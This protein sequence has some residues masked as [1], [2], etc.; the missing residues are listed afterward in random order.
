MKNK[1][2]TAWF[3]MAT[4]SVLVVCAGTARGQRLYIHVER[5]TGNISAV[6]SG[7][8]EVDGYS[9]TS[10]AGLLNPDAWNSLA[11]QG[12]EGWAEA[13][14]R[15]QQL[16]ELNWAGAGAVAAGQPVA[17]GSPYNSAGVVPGQEDLGFQFSTP[18]GVLH[19]GSVQYTGASQVPGIIVNRES[20]LIEVANPLGFEITGY[21]I[22]SSSGALQPDSF[23]GLADQNVAGWEEA[24]PSSTR[25]SKLNLENSLTV[26][27]ASPFNIGSAFVPGGTEDLV[28]EYL[29]LENELGNGLVSYTGPPSNLTLQVDLLSGEAKIQN[30][31]SVAGDFDIIGYSIFSESGSLAVDDWTSFADTG[32]GG[33]GWVEANPSG[34]A[35]AELN[36][37]GVSALFDAG[38]SISI[39]NVFTGAEDLVFEYGTTDGAA[40][41]AVE[42]VLNLGGDVLGDCNRDGVLDAADL[43]C[44]GT[45]EERDAVLTALNTLA[46]DLDGNGDVAFPDFLTLSANFGQ[47]LPS[48]TAGNIDL[49]GGV[50]FPDFLT[51]SAN[52]GK[53]PGGAA[54]AVP[55]PASGLL[56]TSGM[57]L[58]LAIRKRR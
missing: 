45:I 42:Y 20:G 7:D 48:Y 57:L 12:A 54:A 10:S 9:I 36:P 41:G 25:L 26:D 38:K 40:F 35:I 33:Q 21:T 28:F 32:A 55:E 4:L 13:N 29:T 53:T 51:L 11:D 31:S 3:S 14:P 23:N 34:N 5:D 17:L 16:S 56:A 6:P 43:A 39:G 52:F 18:D 49:T 46:G 30:L 15:N 1:K 27:A 37:T 24:N 58:L 47:D 50:A 19:A 8:F 44:V 2:M 22:I